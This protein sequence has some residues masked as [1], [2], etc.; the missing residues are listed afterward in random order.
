D[1]IDPNLLPKYTS[2]DQFTFM[3]VNSDFKILITDGTDSLIVTP[4]E[5]DSG[6]IDVWHGGRYDSD[7]AQLA[8]KMILN[9]S[10]NKYI[11]RPTDPLPFSEE[12]AIK[13]SSGNQTIKY[14]EF[15]IESLDFNGFQPHDV[16]FRS[17]N[18]TG[19]TFKF[20]TADRDFLLEYAGEGDFI[21]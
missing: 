21:S 4:R 9:L 17:E 12:E 7:Y 16:S 20:L 19:A 8:N 18:G 15:V 14:I 6:R 11:F 5:K 3:P 10:K 2:G 13:K 1:A